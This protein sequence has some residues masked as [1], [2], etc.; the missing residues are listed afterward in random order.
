MAYG[1]EEYGRRVY[2]GS[3]DMRHRLNRRQAT[4]ND[5]KAYL[6]SMNLIVVICFKTPVLIINRLGQ[7]RILE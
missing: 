2:S 6:N 1:I 7:P 4:I 3:R 5:S